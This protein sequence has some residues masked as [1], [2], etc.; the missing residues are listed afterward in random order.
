MY[1]RQD[2]R[3][4]ALSRTAQGGPRRPV[5][6]AA[7]GLIGIVHV[8]STPVLYPDSVASIRRGGVVAAVEADPELLPLRG[9]GFW[10]ATAGLGIVALG[11]AVADLERAD[12]LRPRH[13]ALLAA[14]GLWGVVLVPKSGFWLFPPLAA[15]AAGRRRSDSA[16]PVAGRRRPR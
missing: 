1:L 8:V 12:R 5:V 13:A 10:Y 9:L 14:I 6:G 7:L 3:R 15:L 16:Y 2:D 4:L 11:V